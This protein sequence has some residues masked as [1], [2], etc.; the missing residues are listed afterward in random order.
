MRKLITLAVLAGIL[1]LGSG[2]GTVLVTA[3]AGSNVR[4]LAELEPATSKV[5]VKNW[6]VLWG[7]VPITNN[8][9]SDI[10][11]KHGLKDVRIKTYFSFVDALINGVLGGL[12]LY[13]NTVEIEG[14]LGK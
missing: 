10:I 14:N 13:T 1:M 8:N 2:C 7:I 5:T 3:P 11:A 12:S 4:L 6:Y 9:T